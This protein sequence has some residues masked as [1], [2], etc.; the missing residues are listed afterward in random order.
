VHF[1]N[2]ALTTNLCE[3]NYHAWEP[4][5]V[6]LKLHSSPDDPWGELPINTIIGGAY[7]KNDLIVHKCNKICDLDAEELMPYLLTAYYD[8]TMFRDTGRF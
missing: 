7:S 5:Y 1:V 3:Y 2:G 4:A 8:R 6:D